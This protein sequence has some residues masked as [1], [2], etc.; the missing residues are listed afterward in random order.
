MFDMLFSE[1]PLHEFTFNCTLAVL[2]QFKEL[3]PVTLNTKVETNEE[4]GLMPVALLPLLHVYVF[5]PPAVKVAV[6]PLHIS[7]FEAVIVTLGKGFTCTLTEA[8][9]GQLMLPDEVN[10]DTV[11]TVLVVGD[12]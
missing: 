10:A 2:T 9:L 8:L 3:V 4:L 1:R 6:S 5:A 7:F 11:Y 12:T